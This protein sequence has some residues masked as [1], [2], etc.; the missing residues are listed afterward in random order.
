MPS[1]HGPIFPGMTPS[2][3]V[4][5]VRHCLRRKLIDERTIGSKEDIRNCHR[6]K[7]NRR[8][9]AEVWK[10]LERMNLGSVNNLSITGKD[11]L[12]MKPDGVNFKVLLSRRKRDQIG[13]LAGKKLGADPLP[14]DQMGRIRGRGSHG[15][16]ERDASEVT[17]HHPGPVHTER[18]TS[19][20]V[21]ADADYAAT[22][23]Q[24]YGNAPQ[25]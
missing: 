19:E 24:F 3:L 20:R 7:D 9:Y 17:E 15:V 23:F 16:I 22:F 13:G 1:R 5:F 25:S 2:G 18:R 6:R 11:L 14:F 4:L 21:C 8:S 12:T 10:L